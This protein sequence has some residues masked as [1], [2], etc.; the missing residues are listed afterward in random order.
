[1]N[2][3]VLIVSPTMH[4]QS[5]V[6]SLLLCNYREHRALC[7]PGLAHEA[8]IYTVV[9]QGQVHCHSDAALTDADGDLFQEG[10]QRTTALKL[11]YG[12]TITALRLFVTFHTCRMKSVCSMLKLNYVLGKTAFVFLHSEPLIAAVNRTLNAT[13]L[14]IFSH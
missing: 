5:C 6:K 3:L 13:E 14:K 12:I 2:L 11:D 8:G 10:L 7:S 1:M 4:L 9:K